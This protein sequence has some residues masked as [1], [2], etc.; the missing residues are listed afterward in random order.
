MD[1]STPRLAV[2]RSFAARCIRGADAM[3][4]H[5]DVARMREDIYS[6]AVASTWARV[7][8]GSSFWNSAATSASSVMPAQAKNIVE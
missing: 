1:L 4:A 7:R 8:S 5:D 6:P 2:E 3:L